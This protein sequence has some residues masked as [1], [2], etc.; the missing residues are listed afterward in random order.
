MTS[1]TTRGA[2]ANFRLARR[3]STARETR[4]PRRARSRKFYQFSVQKCCS[5]SL[6]SRTMMDKRN[7][8]LH[9]IYIRH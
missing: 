4:S 7:N 2:V 1:E 3:P 9:Y 8:R 6:F 5:S